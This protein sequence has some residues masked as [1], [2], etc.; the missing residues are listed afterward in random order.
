MMVI[1]GPAVAGDS[2]VVCGDAP[3]AAVVVAAGDDDGADGDL[4]LAGFGDEGGDEGRA[5]RF[6]D[7]FELVG[8]A[9]DT[10]LCGGHPAGGAV[11]EVGGEPDAVG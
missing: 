7:S 3:A 2:G 9:E 6:L 11:A 10:D 1:V 4:G 5:E 8:V